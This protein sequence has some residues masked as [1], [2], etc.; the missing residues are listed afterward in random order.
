MLLML[1]LNFE[2]VLRSKFWSMNV[3]KLPSKKLFFNFDGDFVE[4]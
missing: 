2:Q 1:L 3:P 4:R